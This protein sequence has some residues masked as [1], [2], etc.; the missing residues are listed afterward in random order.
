MELYS[1]TWQLAMVTFLPSLQPRKSGTQFSDPRVG[2]AE[3]T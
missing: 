3:L 1:V 2:K